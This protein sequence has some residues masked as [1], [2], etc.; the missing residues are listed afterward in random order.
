MQDPKAT[1]NSRRSSPNLNIV[2]PGHGDWELVE[3]PDRSLS[4]DDS[5]MSGRIGRLR[6]RQAASTP[7]TPA[8]RTLPGMAAPGNFSPSH[9]GGGTVFPPWDRVVDMVYHTYRHE[10]QRRPG[11]RQPHAEFERCLARFWADHANTENT[12]RPSQTSALFARLPI[13]VRFRIWTHLVHMVRHGEQGATRGSSDKPV[14]LNHHPSF[15]SNVWD[16][17]SMSRLATI[18]RPLESC[19]RTAFSLYA[20]VLVTVLTTSTFHAVLSPF[21]GPRLHPLATLWLNKYGAYMRSIIL[22]V[23]MS[24]LGLGPVGAQLGPCL[25]ALGSLLHDFGVAQMQRDEG[26]PLESLVLMC[27]RF[28]GKRPGGTGPAT[29]ASDV[30]PPA[31]VSADAKPRA[32][33]LSSHS[34]SKATSPT[35]ERRRP[36]KVDDHQ[37]QPH[38]DDSVTTIDWHAVNA[39]RK[40]GLA[41]TSPQAIITSSTSSQAK[42]STSAVPKMANSQPVPLARG[43]AR[44]S[45][46]PLDTTSYCPDAY[47]SVCNH[48][49]RLRGRLESLRLVGFGEQYSHQL[50][51]TIFP[52][53]R[54]TRIHEHSYRIAPSTAWPLLPGQAAYLD[55]GHGR[56][57]VLVTKGGGTGPLNLKVK[58][59]PQGPVMPPPPVVVRAVPSLHA[60]SGG[61]ESFGKS[62]RPAMPTP[63]EPV[64]EEH[65]SEPMRATPS[66]TDTREVAP[67]CAATDAISDH[68]TT[69]KPKNERDTPRPSG[70]VDTTGNTVKP[71]QH[72]VV[73]S[74][75][76]R[77]SPLV[78]SPTAYKTEPQL[79]VRSLARKGSVTRS[80]TG[81]DT[82]S[83]GTVSPSTGGKGSRRSPKY[84][85]EDRK[86]AKKRAESRNAE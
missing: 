81:S 4:S 43:S 86:R 1:L 16:A 13:D 76:H 66:G 55:A 70:I 6:Q 77:D 63:S 25:N 67:R 23:D 22:E 46:P 65:Q 49:A 64:I 59:L 14:S 85:N 72:V 24:H 61:V 11:L 9:P 10:D 74:P 45:E 26:H 36:A 34:S 41:K 2:P 79:S 75:T 53:I 33:S 31:A 18:V 5:V 35:K 32:S 57:I 69:P 78:E 52:G 82:S 68:L 37:S 50:L 39:T 58:G 54:E 30:S 20:E 47:L 62:E 29:V 71:E 12:K 83:R 7:I 28:Y 19:L 15:N 3:R 80:V 27:R 60:H 56:G 17:T 40:A 51:A 84:K 42:A 21:V 44:Q 73:A 38:Q 8:D 48:L